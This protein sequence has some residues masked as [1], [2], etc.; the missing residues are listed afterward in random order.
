M[1]RRKQSEPKRVTTSTARCEE[2]LGFPASDTVWFDGWVGPIWCGLCERCYLEKHP[3]N[4]PDAANEVP[5][6]RSFAPLKLSNS[7]ASGDA[8]NLVHLP[9]P[10]C[11]L[12]L[13]DSRSAVE[14]WLGSEAGEWRF[15]LRAGASKVTVSPVDLQIRLPLYDLYLLARAGAL[16]LSW[17]QRSIPRNLETAIEVSSAADSSATDHVLV[18]ELRWAAAAVLQ[19]DPYAGPVSAASL[20]GRLVT[21][22]SAV[23]GHLPKTGSAVAN[24]EGR[25]GDKD[26]QYDSESLFAALAS[27]C[28]PPVETTNN[29]STLA[30][31]L[32][33][34]GLKSTL[35]PFQLA[36]LEWMEAREI[37][38]GQTTN[39][40]LRKP[41]WYEVVDMNQEE[42]FINPFNAALWRRTTSAVPCVG[43]KR[44]NNSS[45]SSSSVAKKAKQTMSSTDGLLANSADGS[46]EEPSGSLEPRLNASAEILDEPL[47]TEA[48]PPWAV[49]ANDC[50]A[51][52]GKGGI[53]ADESKCLCFVQNCLRSHGAFDPP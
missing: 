46:G 10:E 51:I 49:D 6:R 35:Y 7:D 21:V 16:A 50:E 4:A 1:V 3:N 5:V 44:L 30:A 8:L 45:T 19:P 32:A 39:R 23:F 52:E 53:L 36:A 27:A 24:S 43:S 33:D 25:G 37:D 2:C 47:A 42:F 48:A 13:A 14:I 12:P 17:Q 20:P 11:A 22:L 38:D 9:V 41:L 15:E 31:S 29:S 34:A 28:P 40:E 26:P 18:L